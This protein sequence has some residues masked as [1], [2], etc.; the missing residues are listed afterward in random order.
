MDWSLKDTFISASDACFGSCILCIYD[1][2]ILN[3]IKYWT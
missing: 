1:V 2:Q 3:M